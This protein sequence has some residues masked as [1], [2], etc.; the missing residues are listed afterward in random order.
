M[1]TRKGDAWWDEQQNRPRRQKKHK[2]QTRTHHSPYAWRSVVVSQLGYSSYGDYLKSDLWKSIRERV[3]IRDGHQCRYCKEPASQ[4]HHRNYRTDTMSGKDIQD[5]H[6]V[7][8]TCHKFV[9]F[10]GSRKLSMP[11][12]KARTLALVKMASGV[13]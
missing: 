1:T 8:G 4:A 13:Q 5:I 12:M 6:A 2:K 9:E 7:C 11:Q 10:I 3:L